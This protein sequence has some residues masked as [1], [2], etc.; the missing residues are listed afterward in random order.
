MPIELYYWP[1]IQGRGEF[2]RLAL[3]A[4]DADYIDVARSKPGLPALFDLLQSTA[5]D[6]PPFAPPIV[7]VDGLVLAQ[8]AN[9]LLYLGP[10]LGL[11]P[12]DEAGKF[13]AHQCQL[14]IADLVSEVHD[15]HHPVGGGLYYGEQ[16]AEALRYAVAFRSERLPKFLN[17]FESILERN[18]AGDTCL[19][20]DRLTYVDLSMFQMIAGLRYAFPKAMARVGVQVPRLLALHDRVALVSNVARY[21]R[22]TRRLAPNNDDIWRH[23]PELDD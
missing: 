7:K 14:T 18:P 10:Q 2:I 6:Q 13:W 20:G 1:D 3:E 19:I 5:I 23:Y 9:I 16:K 11:A 22:S 12:T 21:L 17:Y 15:T 4:A 8:V